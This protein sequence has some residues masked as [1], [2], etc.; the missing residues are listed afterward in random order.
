MDD[1]RRN[2]SYNLTKGFINGREKNSSPVYGVF[3]GVSSKMTLHLLMARFAAEPI[4]TEISRS[5][6]LALLNAPRAREENDGGGEE[7]GG[8]LLTYEERLKHYIESNRILLSENGSLDAK[9]IERNITYFCSSELEISAVSFVDVIN[10]PDSASALL[11]ACGTGKGNKGW[12]EDEDGDSRKDGSDKK[13]DEIFIECAAVIDPVAGSPVSKLVIGQEVC[14]RLPETS[15]F[16]KICRTSLPGF[17]GIV[18]GSVT[19]T[20]INE[21]GN[22]VVAVSLAEGISGTMKVQGNV[23]IKIAKTAPPDQANSANYEIA[24][25]IALGTVGAALLLL[26]IVM[27]FRFMN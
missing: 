6:L 13:P 9:A 23:W 22:A 20:K 1:I 16:Y 27:L 17:D 18:N 7:R 26:A 10:D 5:E 12:A 3:L 14:C 15:P 11:D 24:R 2:V 19:G 21:F 8:P 4:E 25:D